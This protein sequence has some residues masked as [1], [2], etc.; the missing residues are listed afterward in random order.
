M[1]VQ[2]HVQ[3]VEN[4]YGTQL[5]YIE[6][7]PIQ[8]NTTGTFVVALSDTI[9]G[10]ET[11]GVYE[12][13]WTCQTRAS[14]SYRTVELQIEVGGNVVET[15]QVESENLNTWQERY[16]R[17]FLSGVSTDQTFVIRY[18]RE[19]GTFGDAEIQTITIKKI[20]IK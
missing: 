20:R 10:F 18:R 1:P 15:T 4:L 14:Q 9:A 8:T 17:I 19:N 3:P 5:D 6:L 7:L 2:N 11:D 12:I 13:T 16:G